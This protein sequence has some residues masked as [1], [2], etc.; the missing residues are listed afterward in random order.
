MGYQPY[1]PNRTSLASADDSFTANSNGAS[2]SDFD[3]SEYSSDNES[4]RFPT[5]AYDAQRTSAFSQAADMSTSNDKK[6]PNMQRKGIGANV[7]VSMNSSRL[8][9]LW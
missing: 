4:G 3:F 9:Q 5:Q 2:C 8:R 6:S 1:R 7:S